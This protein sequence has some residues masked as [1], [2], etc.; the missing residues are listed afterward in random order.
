MKS[1]KTSITTRSRLLCPE[2]R[3]LKRVAGV[4][5][6]GGG[7]TIASL[8]CGHDRGEILPLAPGRVS[9]ENLNSPDGRRLFPL[10]A[11]EAPDGVRRKA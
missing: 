3:E 9:L 10:A 8:K 7:T 5:F 2:C 11:H 4:R 6:D 1:P